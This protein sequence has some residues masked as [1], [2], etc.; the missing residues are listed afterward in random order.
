MVPLTPNGGAFR[1]L[2]DWNKKHN[3]LLKEIPVQSGMSAAERVTSIKTGQY[4]A[5]VIPDNLGVL[6]LA[7]KQGVK[8]VA[9][10]EPVKVN[11]TYV[12]VNKK[13]DK[14]AAE[15]NEALKALRSDGTLS[16]INIKWYKN[17][18]MK[19]LK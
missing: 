6:D 4:D 7:E 13:E 1:I 10:A 15:I 17:D 8:L 3:N 14:L 16:K 19:L 9:L 12:L 11:A 18:L 5:L 2:T